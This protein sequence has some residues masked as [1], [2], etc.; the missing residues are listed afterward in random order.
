MRRFRLESATMT[1]TFRALIVV[2]SFVG[3]SAGCGGGVSSD[4]EARRAYL[5]LDTSIGKSLQ[6]G[7]DG[8]NS[9][10]SANIA[11]QTAAG[12]EDGT[13]TITGQ[14]DQGSSDNK[15]MRL[16]V[17]MV[18]YFDGAVTI[19]DN[20]TV[21][22]VY[23]TDVD[24][25][26]QPYLALSLRNIPTAGSTA[27]GDFTGSLTGRYLMSGDLEGEVQLD[28]T[29]GGPIQDDGFGKVVRTPGGTHVIGTATAGAGTYDVDLML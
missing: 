25:A 23:Q 16:Y 28:L 11:P 9:A 4:E 27:T 29:M 18:D 24:V 15:G 17:G 6:L 3:L 1:S 21:E 5:G 26:A 20:A 7:F 22:I 13:L 19:P 2:L 12:N 10:S 14:V 8:F